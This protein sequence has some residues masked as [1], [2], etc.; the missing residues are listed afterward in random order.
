MLIALFGCE[1]YWHVHEDTRHETCESIGKAKAYEQ[2]EAIIQTI[3][4]TKHGHK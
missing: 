3:K 2:V 4:D 1:V